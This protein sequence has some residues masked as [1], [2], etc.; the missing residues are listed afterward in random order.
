MDRPI[1]SQLNRVLPNAVH[2]WRE[3]V[4]FSTIR[5]RLLSEWLSIVNFLEPCL[6][7]ANE[8]LS[9]ANLIRL[10][11]K[12]SELDNAV[13]DVLTTG[14]LAK[15]L[16]RYEVFKKHREYSLI[17]L[18]HKVF[19]QIAVV[20]RDELLST[21]GTIIESREILDLVEVREMLERERRILNGVNAERLFKGASGS[22]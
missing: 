1:S 4:S 7:V 20:E 8:E 18:P 6:I 10:M 3:P 16:T 15:L 14:H 5:S 11:L 22:Q 17:S 9:T 12:A 21:S 13:R 19:D 2:L